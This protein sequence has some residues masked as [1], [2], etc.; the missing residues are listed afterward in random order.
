MGNSKKKHNHH[1][2]WPSVRAQQATIVTTKAAKLAEVETANVTNVREVVR[3][4]QQD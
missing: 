3:V 2:P 4:H 1:R